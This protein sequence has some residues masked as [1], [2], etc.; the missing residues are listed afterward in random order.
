MRLQDS[1]VVNNFIQLVAF[2]PF[3]TASVEMDSI[4]QT[5]ALLKERNIHTIALNFY[6]GM[7]MAIERADSLGIKTNLTVFDSQNKKA[8]I[9]QAV[10]NFKWEGLTQ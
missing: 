4:E 7:A 9:K 6:M 2:L 10:E 1:T 5:A 3:K 8:E